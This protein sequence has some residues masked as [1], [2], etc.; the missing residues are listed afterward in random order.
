MTE[1]QYAQEKID[2]IKNI[3]ERHKNNHKNKNTIEKHITRIIEKVIEVDDNLKDLIC[4]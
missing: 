2:V 3:Q 1:S 4:E